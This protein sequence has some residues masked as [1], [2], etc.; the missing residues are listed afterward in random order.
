MMLDVL[1][2]KGI[3]FKLPTKY[4]KHIWIIST[5][6]NQQKMM[7][8][9]KIN[10]CDDRIINLSQ[11]HIRPIVRGKQ[12]KK[13]EFGS[14]LGVSLANGYAK[15]DTMNWNAYNESSDLP[16]QAQAYKTL[17]GY[18]P[19][20]IQVDKIY[21]TNANRTWCKKRNIRL[22]VATKGK[23][24]ELTKYQKRKR[25]K[26]YAERNQVEGKFG[27]SKQGYNLNEVKAKL[28]STSETWV[29]AIFF[30]VNCVKFA[31]F[32]NFTF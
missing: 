17:Y 6:Y 3:K 21:G 2:Q 26:E 25:K 31:Q 16:M 29:G 11:P 20:L 4:Y 14:K 19:E 27:Q 8:D 28:K 12:G 18:Y 5:F 9:N 23:Q 32:N 24:K 7:Y 13:V 1:E 15:A 22:T 30:V 10:R